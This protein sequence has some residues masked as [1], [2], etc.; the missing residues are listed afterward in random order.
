[1]RRVLLGAALALA[2]AS[3]AAAD[4]ARLGTDLTPVGAERAGN[5]AG[6]IPA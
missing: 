5:A 6:T 3:A 4:A 1:V 2:S